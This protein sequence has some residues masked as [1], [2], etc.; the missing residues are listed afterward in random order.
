MDIGGHVGP[1]RDLVGSTQ[2]DHGGTSLPHQV[3]LKVADWSP[4]IRVFTV[5]FNS[6]EL[7]ELGHRW[8]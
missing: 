2:E 6:F 4:F 7:L 8:Y 3:E 1:T 5:L